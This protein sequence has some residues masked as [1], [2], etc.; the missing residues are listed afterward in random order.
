MKDSYD[1]AEEKQ[2]FG[3]HTTFNQKSEES[4]KLEIQVTVD[5]GTKRLKIA[6]VDDNRYLTLIHV[7]FNRSLPH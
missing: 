4:R 1:G 5:N 7:I 2:I 6:D 3:S